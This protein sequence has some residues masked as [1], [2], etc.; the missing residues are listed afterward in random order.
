VFVRV[1]GCELDW[2]LANA[3][4]SELLRVNT[5]NNLLNLHS[6]TSGRGILNPVLC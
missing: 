2:G 5:R 6:Q 4:F 1:S 3:G